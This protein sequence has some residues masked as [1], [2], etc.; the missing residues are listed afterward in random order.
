MPA[1]IEPKVDSSPNVFL[2][3]LH[4]ARKLETTYYATDRKQ[5]TDFFWYRESGIRVNIGL[6]NINVVPIYYHQGGLLGTEHYQ[7]GLENINVVPM[8]HHHGGLLGTEHYLAGLENINVVP[9]YE[10]VDHQ[11]DNEFV[12]TNPNIGAEEKTKFRRAL[13]TRC[14]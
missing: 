14:R 10:D 6:Q 1:Y 5:L 4:A 8:Y 7:G 12:L 13:D 11:G 9:M 3:N 2:E